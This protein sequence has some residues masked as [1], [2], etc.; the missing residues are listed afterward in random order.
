MADF[1]LNFQKL[2]EIDIT[3][4]ASTRSYKR[5][6]SGISSASPGNNEEIAQDGYLDGDGYKSS[7]VIGAQ[8]I[9]TFS[10]HR[11]KDDDAQN[12][13]FGTQMTL[14]N[15]RKTN[16]REYD[17]VGNLKSGRVTICNVETDQGGALAKSE[18]GFELHYNGKPVETAATI[19]PTASVEIDTGSLTGTTRFSLKKTTPTNSIKYRLQAQSAGTINGMQYISGL[20]EYDAG[21]LQQL[22]A[23]CT[24]GAITTSGNI[25]VTVTAA[26]LTNGSDTVTVA[27]DEDDTAAQVAEKVRVALAAESNVGEVGGEFYIERTDATITITAKSAAANDVL[28][29]ITVDDTGS[30]GVVFA[31]AS[32][33]VDGVVNADIS[34]VAGQFL[35]CFEVDA[36]I[37]VVS[38]YEKA[39]VSGDIKSA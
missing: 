18:I 8:R 15:D 12:F 1:A 6:A 20:N 28:Y 23:A 34:A 7:D 36:N 4:G 26:C 16:F 9:W 39:L 24:T 27:V 33:A 29:N 32:G 35:Q 5:V 21:T 11:D 19:A 25:D 30:T 2:L 10:G 14:G 22:S 13:I 17:A 31:S 37:R 3:P 38:F